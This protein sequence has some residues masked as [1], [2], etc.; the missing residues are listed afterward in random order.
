MKMTIPMINAVDWSGFKS[1]YSDL[2]RKDKDSH[3]ASYLPPRDSE[4]FQW[5]GKSK[6]IKYWPQF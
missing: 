6:K 1:R 2:S 4:F 3:A 5:R